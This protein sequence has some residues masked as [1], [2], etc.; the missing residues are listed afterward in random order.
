MKRIITLM[1]FLICLLPISTSNASID[2]RGIL[3]EQITVGNVTL[4]KVKFIDG[5]ECVLAVGQ[6]VSMAIALQC[7]FKDKEEG[8]EEN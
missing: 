6:S 1:M 4:R 2:K 7:K 5:T 8:A 3:K